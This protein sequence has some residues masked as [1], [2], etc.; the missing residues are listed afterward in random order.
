MADFGKLWAAQSVSAFGSQITLLALPLTAIY[1]LH[2]EAWQIGLLGTAEWLPFLLF[3]LPAG[4]W[5]DRRTRR[6]VLIAADLGR[7]MLL[8]AV[9]VAAV[10]AGLTF[11]LLLAL[12][13][14]F[15]TCTVLFEVFYYSYVPSL[16]SADGLLGANS[17]LQASESVAQIGGPGVGGL[18]VQAVT[19]PVALLADAVSFLVS[20]LALAG[21]RTRERAPAAS[22]A[23]ALSQLREGLAFSIRNRL[24]LTL[25][26]TAAICNFFL[27]WIMVLF[28]LFC[29]RDLRLGAGMIGLILAIGAVGGLAGSAVTTP[30]TRRFGLGPVTLWTVAGECAALML[31][32]A[33]TV[34]LM[35]A[36]WFGCG[37]SAAISRVVSISIRQSVTPGPL[38]GRVNATHRFV[39]YGVI[40]LG[41]VLGGLA[42]EVLGLRTALLTGAMG[43]VLAVV[44]VLV[45]PLRRI[46]S[47]TV[48]ADL[49]DPR[50][51]IRRRDA[52]LDDQ[53]ISCPT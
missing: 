31:L 9:V 16:V 22:G 39:S 17:R 7:G 25:L 46:R 50:V 36:G 19:A 53:E 21:I 2:A 8:T 6:P 13:F 49:S 4:V 43:M 23:R 3:A 30:L 41:T 44:C 11:P 32:P 24:V 27:Q 18:L 34:A 1:T 12:T 37:F 51:A 26:G 20:G 35:V 28:T 48:T 45:S 47:A 38:L 15:G 10:T 29:V 14:A 40:A 5:G 52:T 33:G 42:G